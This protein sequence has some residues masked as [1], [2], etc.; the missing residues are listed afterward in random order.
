MM[1]ARRR[2]F[3]Q[4]GVLGATFA[5]SG[6]SWAARLPVAGPR[7]VVVFLRGAVDGLNVVIPYTEAAYYDHRPTIAIARP[8][9]SN[10]ALDLDGRFGLHPALAPLLPLWTERSLAFI[11]GCGSPD[12]SRSHFQ[13]QADMES[14]CLGQPLPSGWMNRL[15]QVWAQPAS[16]TTGVSFTAALPH[17]F[18]GTAVATNFPLGPAARRKTPLDRPQIETVFAPLYESDAALGR[19]YHDGLHARQELLGALSHEMADSG[20]GAYGAGPFAR[21]AAQAGSLLASDPSIRFAFLSIAGWDTHVNEGNAHGQ[22]ATHLS[23]LARGLVSL[24]QN[25]GPAYQDTVIY[26]CSEFGRTVRENGNHGTD[27]GHGNVHWMLGGPIKGGR[28]YGV[29]P[30][31]DDESLYQG[32]DLAVTTDYRACIDAVLERH[33]ELSPGARQQVLPGWTQSPVV[34]PI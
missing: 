4:L 1:P 14:A 6:R 2:F 23:A 28:V 11:H 21:D 12:P 20:Q 22:L 31:L 29:W 8:G 25:L 27:H 18:S 32:R 17:I 3:G 19:A 30:G 26:V 16:A 24:K 15:L 9:Q 5:L 33:L 10:G 34:L 7:L 13:A